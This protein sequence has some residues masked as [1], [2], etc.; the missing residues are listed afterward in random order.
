MVAAPSS[1]SLETLLKTRKV[2]FSGKDINL[3]RFQEGPN[4]VPIQPSRQATGANAESIRAMQEPSMAQF[5]ATEARR[6]ALINYRQACPLRSRLSIERHANQYFKGYRGISYFPSYSLK[7]HA[8]SPFLK[9]DRRP[10]PQES[11]G[12]TAKDTDC[13]L[14]TSPSPRDY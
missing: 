1:W 11:A 14:Y 7:F 5:L 4:Y 12:A 6:A 8:Q 13:L 9:S 10:E 3:A 2:H